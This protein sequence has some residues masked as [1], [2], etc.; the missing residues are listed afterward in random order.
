MKIK[1]I[2]LF[3]CCVKLPKEIKKPVVFSELGP[4]MES[5]IVP[6]LYQPTV[7]PDPEEPSVELIVESVI[8]SVVETVESV[9]ETVE[10]V[11]ET[12]ESVIETVES[13]IENV[14]IE[15]VVENV[16]IE[17]VVEVV[18]EAI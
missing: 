11:V 10:S 1:V 12:V 2:K 9:V 3:T 17:A 13:V 16:S 6:E 7:V 5:I 8:E 4:P 15:P 18:V 14:S